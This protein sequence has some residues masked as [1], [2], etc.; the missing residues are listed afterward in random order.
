MSPGLLNCKVRRNC[1]SG[2]AQSGVHLQLRRSPNVT[3]IVC[4]SPQGAMVGSLEALGKI[5][6]AKM[7][8]PPRQRHQEGGITWKRADG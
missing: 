5:P 2:A 7:M 8:L 6:E 1:G 4:S 3:I